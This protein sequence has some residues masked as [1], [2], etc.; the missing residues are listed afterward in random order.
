MVAYV[1]CGVAMDNQNS[2]ALVPVVVQRSCSL[3]CDSNA[4]NHNELLCPTVNSLK[5]KPAGVYD[6]GRC[7]EAALK[8]CLNLVRL[9]GELEA[10]L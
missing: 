2:T 6:Q 8:T 4:M 10:A 3:T 9:E 7:L 1:F 5:L